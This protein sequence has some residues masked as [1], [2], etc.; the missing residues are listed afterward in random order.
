MRYEYVT[1]SFTFKY[2]QDHGIK[3]QHKHLNNKFF[4]INKF[5]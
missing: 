1:I 3:E 5:V 2:S 4:S